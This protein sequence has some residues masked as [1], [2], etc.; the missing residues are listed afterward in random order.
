PGRDTAGILAAAAA[1]D[2]QALLIGGVEVDDLP[3]PEAAVAALD[4]TPFVVSLELRRSAVTDRA[5]VVFPVAPVAEKS[6]TFVNWEGRHRPF[7]AALPAAATADMRVL[8]A[9]ADEV[10][11]DLRLTDAATVQADLER[12]GSWQ[13]AR[14]A[15]PTV[16][17]AEVAQPGPGD[18]VLAGWRML[19]DE[20]RLQDGEPHLAG[21]ARPAVARLSA[22]TASEI[23][24][25]EGDPVRISTDRG[26]LRLPVEVTEMP[27]RVVWV[28]LNSAGSVHKVLGAVG[29][30]VRIE[31]A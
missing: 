5:D 15:A 27:D 6:G 10:G 9:L 22:T 24:C 8:A 31:P 17:P 25:Q 28:P 29:T 13:G 18:A 19:L 7:G 1:G 21:T 2:I 11:V 23:G 4:L 3:D 16:P 26:E 20:G 14:A 30:T 12:L